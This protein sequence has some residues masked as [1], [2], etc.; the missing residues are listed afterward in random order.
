[1]ATIHGAA[2]LITR[3]VKLRGHGFVISGPGA[4]R[5]ADITQPL[6]ESKIG[7]FPV[8]FRRSMFAG[9]GPFNVVLNDTPA[10]QLYIPTILR[11]N[12][13][14]TGSG[15]SA[16]DQFALS[17]RSS[18][19][20][21][22]VVYWGDGTSDHITT[23]NAAATTHTYT[24]PGIYTVLIYGKCQG[25]GFPSE[26]GDNVKI[27]NILLFG[28]SI[29]VS[30]GTPQAFRGCSNLTIV[31]VC[32]TPFLPAGGDLGSMFLRCVQLTKIFHLRDW[33]FRD[34]LNNI[35]YVFAGCTV[36][37]SPDVLAWDTKNIRY[38]EGTF[39][40]TAKFNQDIS[41]W[42]VEN[43]VD[44]IN[45]FYGASGFKQ[46]LGKWWPRTATPVV[47][48]GG[49]L[50]MFGYV[51]LN[52][53]GT[54]NYDGLLT[55]WTGWNAGAPGAKGLALQPNVFLDAGV[56]HYSSPEA[57]AA[58]A[59]LISTKGWTIVDGGTP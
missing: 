56:S 3:R 51:D 9:E 15:A 43:V 33:S 55:G 54:A 32:D 23:W 59:W 53:V 21:D 42:N 20:Y 4:T 31:T 46:N 29:D 49:M 13:T 11:I 39:A 30:F 35:S 57:A 38:M 45:L 28:N 25:F 58:R 41:G 48:P 50:R 19:T 14:K 44:F 1:M 2:A 34:G 18:G 24:A 36:F 10:P 40:Q 7:S 27:T 12:T 16:S 26:T 22:F 47:W 6:D 37:N 17:L 8:D 5:N 52:S